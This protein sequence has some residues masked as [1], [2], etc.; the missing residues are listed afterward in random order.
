MLSILIAFAVANADPAAGIQSQRIAEAD[1]T[2]TLTHEA[3]VEAPITEVWTAV[4]T[5]EGWMTWAVPIAWTG[6]DDP[7]LLE[8]AYDPAAR[9]GQPQTIQQRVILRV[10]GRLLAFR[11]IKAPAGFPH[12][13]RFARVASVF[14]L[15]AQGE[16]RTRVRL[17]MAGYPDD[18]AGRQLLGFFD[19]GNRISLERLQRRFRSGPIDWPEELRRAAATPRSH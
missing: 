17:T 3:V 13:E 6:P 5:P 15:A 2:H 7:D 14:E 9:P 18:E 8:T 16:Q 10:P 12:F 1:A 19:E 4:S 11:T